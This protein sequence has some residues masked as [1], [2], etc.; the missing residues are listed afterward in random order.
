MNP[1]GNAIPFEPHEPQGDPLA[2]AEAFR[3]CMS[4]RRSV[5]MF[6]R[7]P[8]D[9]T[10]IE[11]IVAT[12][13]TAPSGANKQPWRFVLVGDPDTKRR[14]REAAEI[15]ERAF[16]EERASNDWLKDLLQLQTG[17]EK[18]FLEDAPW[19][20][21]VFKLMK[22]DCEES[23]SD[24]VYYVNESVGIAVGLLLAAAQHA[25]LATL[26]H[27]PSPMGFLSELLGRPEYERPYVLIPIGWAAE[28]CE[29]PNIHRKRLDEIL[30]VYQSKGQG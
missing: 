20:I 28:D 6:S 8:V 18:A 30:T 9:L 29:V 23:Q 14:I 16:Y 22:D 3:E 15:E 27:T 24:R 11:S 10:L 12:A 5:R 13:G 17:P 26:T 19:L 4:K 2:A 25:G 7:E 21:V 1:S